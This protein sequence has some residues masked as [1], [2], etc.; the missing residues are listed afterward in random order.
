[1]FFTSKGRAY[2]LKAYQIPE[3]KREAKGIPIINLLPHLEAG[4]TLASHIPVDK[5]DDAR[6]L[7]FVTNRGTVKKTALSAFSNIR[8]SG[9]IATVLDEK[10]RIVDVRLCKDDDEVVIATRLG[11][12]ARFDVKAARAMGRN[13]HGVIGIRLKEKDEVIGAAVV[14]PTDMLLSITELGYGKRSPVAAYRKTN[15]A[16][17]GVKNMKITEKGKGVV[18]VRRVE[19][20]DQILVTTKSGMMIRTRVAEISV[21]GRATQ[22]VRIIRIDEG[23]A[24]VGVARL[25]EGEVEI[26]EY[27]EVAET[28]PPPG[29]EGEDED[30]DEAPGDEGNGNG[31]D[32]PPPA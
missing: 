22:G 25:L 30:E 26:G 16:A 11:K 24:V 8:V 27:Q 1:M 29:E 14:Q 6:F 5:F 2:W 7:L 32:A 3:G 20:S 21:L 23:D 4:E 19:E 9:I 18:A 28:A 15:R 12:A 17:G 10:E 31:G 13:A